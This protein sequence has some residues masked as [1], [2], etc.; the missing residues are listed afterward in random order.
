[1][2]AF[3]FQF[4]NSL[5][6]C[7]LKTDVIL[8]NTTKKCFRHWSNRNLTK[9]IIWECCI[10][11]LMSLPTCQASEAFKLVQ[12]CSK[13]FKLV[14]FGPNLSKYFCKNWFQVQPMVPELA[15]LTHSLALVG[16]CMYYID[17]VCELTWPHFWSTILNRVNKNK[18]RFKKINYLKKMKLSRNVINT[19]CSPNL[20][21]GTSSKWYI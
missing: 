1:M 11:F 8:W 3:W 5:V 13:Y 19:S 17:C 14:I 10:S 4:L 15:S 2:E 12:T 21:T 16:F 6:I 18:A 20:I 9:R 7:I